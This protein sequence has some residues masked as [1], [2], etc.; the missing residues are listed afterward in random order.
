MF[1]M[2]GNKANGPSGGGH[3]V[4]QLVRH[5]VRTVFGLHGAHLDAIFQACRIANVRVIDTRSEASAGHAAEGYAR[6]S[7]K[8][9]VALVTAGGGLTNALTS[10]ANA[11]LDRTPVLY[12][13]SSAPRMGEESNTLQSGFDQVAMAAPVTKWAHRV[14]AGENIPRLV[15]QAIRIATAAPQGPVMLEIPFELLAMPVETRN[16]FGAQTML[17]PSIGSDAADRILALLEAAERPVILVGNDALRDD[18]R[19]ALGRLAKATGIP[20]MADY[21]G[22]GALSHLESPLA[23]GLLDNLG[24]LSDGAAPDTML[25][26]GL[27]FGLGTR[28]GSGQLIRHDATVVQVDADAREIGRLQPVSLG[29]V[30]DVPAT[31]GALAERAG[32][33]RWPDRAA[34]QQAVGAARRRRFEIVADRVAA[35]AGGTRLHPFVA[36]RAVAD[37]VDPKVTV[38]GDGALCLA[39]M[40]EVIEDARP[41]AFLS[42]GNLGS[43]GSGFGLAIGAAVADAECGRRTVLVTGDG[44]VGYGLADFDTLVRH[45]IPLVVV[46]MNN[47]SWGA[48]QHFQEMRAGPEAVISTPLPN[49]SYH[50]A[51]AAL[52]ALGFGVT[53]SKELESALDRAL[54]AN[55]PA[56]LD[57]EVDLAP[58]PPV[59]L[60]ME[61]LD[62]YAKD[63]PA[64]ISGMLKL[65]K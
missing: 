17:L 3:V 7:G 53:S 44:A 16:T 42:L 59:E 65:R 43:M 19:E 39:W 32:T 50:A 49:G 37:R 6:I 55:R 9:G 57:V 54:A 45:G 36:S 29:L 46:V 13:T 35:A 11:L 52:G 41:N 40:T 61:G 30:A 24:M 63:A 15:A 62:P 14:Q 27:R 5:G 34:W 8:L 1:N 25:M 47:R 20:V 58:I 10:F 26:L 28:H 22:L 18:A 48:T 38:V 60:A 51:A 23:A 12:L 56:C 21:Q 2:G 33:R 64:T 31:L 4:E